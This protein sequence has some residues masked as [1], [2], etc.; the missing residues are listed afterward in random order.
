VVCRGIPG[1]RAIPLP[2]TTT[3]PVRSRRLTLVWRRMHQGNNSAS[4]SSLG[5]GSKPCNTLPAQDND[6]RRRKPLWHNQ[7][8]Q[9]EVTTA[10]TSMLPAQFEHAEQGTVLG[11]SGPVSRK[12]HPKKRRK[13]LILNG[14][15]SA[16]C[17]TRTYNPLIKSLANPL[18]STTQGYVSLGKTRP[19]CIS[20]IGHNRATSPPS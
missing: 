4:A 1:L 16:P 17:R 10:A 3:C 6:R 5:H 2:G 19:F 7:L 11:A 9:I 18:R 8:E 13:P 12:R 20:W 15:R 14:L